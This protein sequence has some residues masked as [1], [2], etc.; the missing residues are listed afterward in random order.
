M[1][2]QVIP[3]TAQNTYG[4]IMIYSDSFLTVED[5]LRGEVN[6]ENPLFLRVPGGTVNGLKL[7]VTQMPEFF[8]RERYLVFLKKNGDRYVPVRGE[9]GKVSL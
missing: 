5:R 2:N 4:K 1:V 9:W 3:L 7:K 8:Q 6:M